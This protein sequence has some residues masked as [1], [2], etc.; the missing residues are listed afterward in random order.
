MYLCHSSCEILNVGTLE[1]WLTKVATWVK[2]HPYDVV[3][4]LMTNFDYVAPSL[5]VEPV[6]NSGL[7]NFRYTPSKIPMALDDW[8]TLSE[9]ILRS[10]RVVFFLDYQANQTAYP[11]LLDEFSQ[12]W[13][14]PFSPT[15]R[16]FPCTQQRPPNLARKDALNRMYM[17]NHNLNIDLAL[18]SFSMLIPNTAVINET[19]GVNGTGSLGD[20]ARNCTGKLSFDNI[21]I[22]YMKLTRSQLC[23]IALPTSSLSITITTASS[24]GPCSRSLRR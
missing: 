12:M 2:T 14:T 20:M 3:T 22:I 13:E 9:M 15:D 16:N 24:T 7:Y 21:H 4:I 23:G 17:A 6:K 11:W 5:F 18:G 19:N 10:Q 8:P 1:A